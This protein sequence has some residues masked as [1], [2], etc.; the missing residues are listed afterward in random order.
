MCRIERVRK[1]GARESLE[2]VHAVTSLTR[3][4][5]AGADLL[6]LSRD[7]WGIENRL[8]CV[9]DVTL[10][11]D[12]C[13]LR[14]LL[15]EDNEVN[16]KLAVR[17]MEKQQHTVAVAGNGQKALEMLERQGRDPFD[18]ILMDVQMPVMGGFEATA[19]IRAREIRDRRHTY[20]VAMTAH[21]MQGYRERCLEAGMDDYIAKPIR[22]PELLR[23]LQCAADTRSAVAQGKGTES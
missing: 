3:A 6:K 14:V 13:R 1:I 5:A 18:L 22:R 7:H 20:I 17:I 10:R 9:R 2:V 16:Q 11:E 19:A 8:H 23:A 15:V 12:R 4:R 21:A